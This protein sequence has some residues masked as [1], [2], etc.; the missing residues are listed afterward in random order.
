MN[1]QEKDILANRWVAQQNG[2][3]SYSPEE[4]ESMA[5]QGIE[6][7]HRRKERQHLDAEGIPIHCGDVLFTPHDTCCRIQMDE[8][9]T[10]QEFLK[11]EGAEKLAAEFV[12]YAK[13]NQESYWNEM[14][15]NRHIRF[16][17][18]AWS[19]E[20]SEK[21]FE[22]RN[23]SREF[24]LYYEDTPDGFCVLTTIQILLVIASIVLFLIFRKSFWI[25]FI[26]GG[27]ALVVTTV[28]VLMRMWFKRV[29]AIR[30]R[31]LNDATE[32]LKDAF[33]IK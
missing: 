15:E 12:G 19:E 22:W 27:A 6:E 30:K 33:G 16:L 18:R 29:R 21:Y 20:E 26:S 11:V 3:L 17:H 23:I 31:E 10:F 5:K 9:H 7:L 1:N 32:Q 14:L 28:N 8:F 2:S 4:I 13:C 25:P 24:W